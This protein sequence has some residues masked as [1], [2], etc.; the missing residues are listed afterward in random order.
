MRFD[1][2]AVG[3]S[4]LDSMQAAGITVLGIEAGRTLMLEPGPMVAEAN[5]R[6][7]ILVGLGGGL[8]N[9]QQGVAT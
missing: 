1:V 7:Q 9:G 6:G 8:D 5:R 4:T 2:P 3:I